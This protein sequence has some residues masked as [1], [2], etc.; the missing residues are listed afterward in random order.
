MLFLR[1]ATFCLTD[2]TNRFVALRAKGMWRQCILT[3]CH[4]V[5]IYGSVPQNTRQMAPLF[6]SMPLDFKK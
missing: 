5:Y 1:P 3:L 2:E 6:P 4:H